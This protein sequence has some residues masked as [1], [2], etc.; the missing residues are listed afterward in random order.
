MQRRSFLRSAALLPLGGLA[1]SVLARPALAQDRRARTLR[2]VPQAN[3]T[4]LDPILTTAGVTADHGYAVFDTLYGM[5]GNFQPQP[6]MLEGHQVEDDGKRWDLT[7]RP[8]LLWHDGEK[9]LARDCVASIQRWAKRDP[10]G[11]TLLATTEELSAPDDRTI[12][13]RLK[14]PFPLLPVALGKTPSPMCAM[15]PERLARTDAFQQVP[16]LIGSGPFRFK[17]DERVPGARNVYERFAGYRPREGGAPD[18]TAGPKI[19]HYDRVVWNTMPDIGTATAALQNGEQDWMEYAYHDMLPLL[20][21]M[22]D[23]TVQVPDPTGLVT[24]LRVNHLQPPFDNPA[25]RRAL[26]PA[27]DQT[28]YMQALT[29]GDPALF[30]V[31]VG[32]FCP[33]TP[34]ATEA[35]LEV[36]R[37]GKDYVTVRDPDTDERLRLRGRIYEKDWNDDA[38]LGR[39]AAREVGE[40][41]GRDRGLDRERAAEALAACE[42]EREHRA[43]R[44]RDRYRPSHAWDQERAATAEM[45]LGADLGRADRELD[46]DRLLALALEPALEGGGGHALGDVPERGAE[47]PGGARERDPAAMHH[48]LGAESD[49]P[50]YEEWGLSHG[51]AHGIGARLARTVQALGERVRSIGERVRGIF[52]EGG[53]MV[54]AHLAATISDRG[55]LVADRGHTAALERGL[56]ELERGLSQADRLNHALG[57][58]GERVAERTLT[59]VQER[60][61]HEWELER[62]ARRERDRGHDHEL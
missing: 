48:A 20:R 57:A 10:F 19:V 35:G 32:F 37:A 45:D 41:D 54:A 15:M 9:V 33:K 55:P 51:P 46:A 58:A 62:A 40:P 60:K 52:E 18:W 24:M 21:G 25:I 11:A 53:R 61:A 34:M 14:R 7:L 39:A 6:Q 49:L 44:N 13:F 22:K 2:F 4:V 31:P 27:I 5:D 43:D 36:T 28:A 59:L 56:G 16:E 42:R 12:R 23:V 26:L 29:G 30:H 38:E 3:L 50:A 8:G 17:A 47:L 1:P